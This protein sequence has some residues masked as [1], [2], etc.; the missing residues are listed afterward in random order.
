[1]L[2]SN[3]YHYKTIWFFFFF[4]VLHWPLSPSPFPLLS[5]RSFDFLFP[6]R[7]ANLS[8]LL[9]GGSVAQ[10]L[11]R[12]ICNSCAPSLSPG[13]VLGSPI[14]ILSRACKIACCFASY[15]FG[16]LTLLGPTSISAIN[17]A[18]GKEQNYLF[19]LYRHECFTGKYSYFEKGCREK[20]TRQSW[21]ALWVVLSSLFFKEIWKNWHERPWKCVCEC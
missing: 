5:I 1:M 17:I 16:F 8:F 19:L 15:Q 10:W 21:K 13:F 3:V 4:L 2:G 14:R 11:E 18:Q 7:S 12:W 9:R 6:F 20:Y